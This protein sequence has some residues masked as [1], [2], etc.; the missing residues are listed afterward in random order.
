VVT[1]ASLQRALDA[2]R[3][4]PASAPRILLDRDPAGWDFVDVVRSRLGPLG[5][6]LQIETRGAIVHTSTVATVRGAPSLLVTPTHLPF[7]AQQFDVVFAQDTLAN[8]E[9]VERVLRPAGFF[10][11]EQHGE[12]S[13]RNLFEAFDWGSY[14][15]YERQRSRELGLPSP[16]AEDI[17]SEFGAWAFEYDVFME[18]ET[19]VYLPDI[20][21]LVALIEAGPFP[22]RLNALRHWR[23]LNHVIAA[24][25]TPRGIETSVHRE[26]LI[27]ERI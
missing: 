22:E 2:L 19:K 20:E 27:V 11:S 1:P 10:I 26:L 23:A 4:S 6:A 24:Y 15:A 18:Y 21:S 25:S 7:R 8:A 16:L 17:G 14:G 5:R 3:E 13:F 9:E 12:R